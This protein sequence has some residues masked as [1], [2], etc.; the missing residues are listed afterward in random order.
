MTITFFSN[1]LNHH[2]IPFCN[3]MY[4][5]IG[6]DFTFVSTIPME[7][8]R[9]DMG[10]KV[11]SVAVYEIRTYQDDEQL[12]EAMRLGAESDVVII[13]TAPESFIRR[14]RKNCKLTFRYQERLRKPDRNRIHSAKRAAKLLWETVTMANRKMFVLCASA[15]TAGDY[16]LTGSYLGRCYKWGYFPEFKATSVDSLMQKKGDRRVKIVWVGRMI[17]WKHVEHAVEVAMQLKGDSLSFHMELIGSGEDESK[18]RKMVR[19]LGLEDRV[20][21]AGVLKPEEVRERMMAAHVLLFTSDFN[22]GWG[23]VLNEA[24]SSG[25]TVV[26]SHAIGSVPYLIRHGE[27]GLIYKSDDVA[28]LYQNVQRIVRDA[29]C[30]QKM[31]KNAYKTIASEWNPLTAAERFIVLSGDLLGDVRSMRFASGPCSPAP[32]VWNDWFNKGRRR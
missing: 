4:S 29:D 25:C 3:A 23:V 2:Q 10:W 18:I 7:E 14:R 20:T 5:M 16:A 11:E 1:Y 21:F 24:M 30:A 26:A 17:Y 8:E 15:Y 22:E 27:N 32:L 19:D 28:D 12:H 31:G 9:R 13:G 6:A